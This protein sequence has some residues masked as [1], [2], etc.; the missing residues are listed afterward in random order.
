MGASLDVFEQEPLLRTVNCGLPQSSDYAPCFGRFPS[1]V[2]RTDRGDQPENLAAYIHHEE[3]VSVV[4]RA[5]G[6][7]VSGSL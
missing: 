5:T 4:D 6:Y 7:K 1:S 3:Y 2:Y